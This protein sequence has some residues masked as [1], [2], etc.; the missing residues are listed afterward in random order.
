MSST[1]DDTVSQLP[2]HANTH[3]AEPEADSIGCG[4]QGGKK[5][6]GYWLKETK[7]QNG[8]I[9]RGNYGTKHFSVTVTNRGAFMFL[10]ALK[11]GN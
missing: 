3:N 10:S 2:V 11:S 1:L 5:G 6:R 7:F 9:G 4:P 8:G